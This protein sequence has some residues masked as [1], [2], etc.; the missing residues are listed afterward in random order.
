[1]AAPAAPAVGKR[2]TQV[3]AVTE[4]EARGHMS[5]EIRATQ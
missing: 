2:V 1:V 5:S 4:A 3:V